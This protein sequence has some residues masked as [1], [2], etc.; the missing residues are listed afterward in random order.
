VCVIIGL[1]LGGRKSTFTYSF[2]VCAS[3]G[4]VSNDVAG[5]YGGMTYVCFFR[6]GYYTRMGSVPPFR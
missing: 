5:A 2:A 6:L 4:G 1:K 3:I